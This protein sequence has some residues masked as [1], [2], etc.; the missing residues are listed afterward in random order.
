MIFAEK[1]LAKHA[2][3]LIFEN[4][5]LIHTRNFVN[6]NLK[7]GFFATILRMPITL[8]RLLVSFTV[9]LAIYNISDAAIL[10]I[11]RQK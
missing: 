1:K 4:A 7:F 3:P 10:E 8:H 11:F 5:P 6:V 9:F 2:F